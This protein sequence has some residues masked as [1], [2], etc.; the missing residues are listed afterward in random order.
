MRGF[1][2]EERVDGGL[3]RENGLLFR[4]TKSMEAGF[5]RDAGGIVTLTRASLPG[6]RERMERSGSRATLRVIP[7]SVDLEQFR[8]DPS[9]N[10]GPPVLAYFG[11]L[12][13][14]YLLEEMLM[15]GQAFLGK[16]PGSRLRFLLNGEEERLTETARKLG[17]PSDRMEV[18]RVPH[19][20][21]PGA[22][23]GAT[24]SFFLIKAAPS[25]AS[26]SATKFG[27]S[28][29]LG[30]PVILNRGIGDSAEVVER[31]RVGVVVDELSSR[32]YETAVERIQDLALDVET[33]RRCREVAERHFDLREAVSEYAGL[34]GDVLTGA[35]PK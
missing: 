13:T 14:W 16:A 20:G 27:E 1:Y 9:P 8:P 17:L 21:I 6:L 31:Y 19:G 11:S 10:P 23:R 2:P 32:A 29:A 24:A 4:V 18:R 22:L 5:L 35:A 30:L 7:T 28:M 12:G 33:S 25:K 15:L 34:Y 3:W 26:S